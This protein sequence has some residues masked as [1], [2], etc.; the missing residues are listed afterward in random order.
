MELMEEL[1]LMVEMVYEEKLL[2]FPEIFQQLINLLYKLLT[3]FIIITFGKT[4]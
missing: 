3:N 1:D 2:Q 4:L